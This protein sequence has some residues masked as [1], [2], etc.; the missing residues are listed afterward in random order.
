MRSH[1]LGIEGEN[2]AAGYLRS[3][4]YSIL[5]RNWR[6]GKAEVDII[7]L[8][9]D[10]LAVVEVKSRSTDAFGMPEQFIDRTKIRLLRRAIN[11]YVNMNRLDHEIRFDFIGIL[12]VNG[13]EK[14]NHL[15]DACY[16]FD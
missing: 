15:K 9:D 6:Y 3:K 10:I 1:V 7:A 13:Q 2:L 11:A 16:I 4:G 5:E 14:I 8:K 12:L